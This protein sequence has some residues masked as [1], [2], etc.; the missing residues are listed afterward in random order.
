MR[1]PQGRPGQP[2]HPGAKG[3]TGARG[4]AGEPFN[5][6]GKKSLNEMFPSGKQS[7]FVLPNSKKAPTSYTD[8]LGGDDLVG[9]D[10]PN[11]KYQHSFQYHY[12]YYKTDETKEEKED[13]ENE[14]ANNMYDLVKRLNSRVDME[15]HPNGT[16]DFPAES[17]RTIHTC[18]PEAPSGNFIIF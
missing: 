1:G 12:Q 8:Y 11:S 2:G 3:Q 18:Y 4:T 13:E 6:F 9:D 14:S 10:K 5:P 15:M 16:R 7:S 17:C